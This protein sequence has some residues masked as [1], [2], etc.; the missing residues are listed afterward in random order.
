MS[1]EPTIPDPTT[2]DSS[3]GRRA[4]IT[5][6]AILGA[7]GVASVAHAPAASAAN[8]DPLRLGSER[9]EATSPTKM[10]MRGARVGVALEV[11]GGSTCIYGMNTGGAETVA[12]EGSAVT[13]VGVKGSAMG[14]TGVEGTSSSGAQA[15][16]GANSATRGS[17][18]GVKGTTA[19]GLGV[20]VVGEASH[21][22]GITQGVRGDATASPLGQGVVGLGQASGVYGESRKQGGKGVHGRATQEAGAASYGVYG[23]SA[24]LAGG[25]GVFGKGPVIDPDLQYMASSFGVYSDG[26]I[27]SSGPAFLGAPEYGSLATLDTRLQDGTMTFS[28]DFTSSS[29]K[30]L[31]YVKSSDGTTYKAELPLTRA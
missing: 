7:A 16:L 9:N 11:T 23:E 12:V 26:G 29:P 13:G 4:L 8:N 2:P 27:G 1:T 18:V 15:I 10:R 19:A 24:T 20:G 17:G 22:S 31:I 3:L 21:A 25:V 28:T 5:G 14:G 6:A 30:L